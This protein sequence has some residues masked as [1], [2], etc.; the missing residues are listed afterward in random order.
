MKVGGL[1]E[2]CN[3]VLY[4]ITAN[5]DRPGLA[6]DILSRFGQKKINLEYLTEGACNT[7]HAVISFCLDAEK[8]EQVDEIIKKEFEAHSLTI[9]K[10]EYVCILGIYGPHFREKPGIAA[11]FCR[12]LGRASVNILGISSSISTVSCVIDIRDHDQ[13]RKAILEYFELP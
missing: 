10:K 5:Q 3:L 2:Q 13:A 8:D 9:R 11:T 12:V 7:D 6:A 4:T 1:V